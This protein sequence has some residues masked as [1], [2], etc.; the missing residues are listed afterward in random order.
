MKEDFLNVSCFA[1]IS[2]KVAHDVND[3][4]NSGYTR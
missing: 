4:L 3:V 1:R 2:T